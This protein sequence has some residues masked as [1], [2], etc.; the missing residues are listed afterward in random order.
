MTTLIEKGERDRKLGDCQVVRTDG[1]TIDG[2]PCERVDV[3]HPQKRV[4]H[5]G[6]PIDHEFFNA[7]I[8]FDKEKHIPLK[9]AS[10]S[11]PLEEGGE[12]LLDEEYTY[13]ELQLNVGLDDSDFDT[14]HPEYRFP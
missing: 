11:W 9:Y 8:W 10:Y 4:T 13:T 3:I 14:E 2:R 1:E 5:D 12:P 7:R 6:A